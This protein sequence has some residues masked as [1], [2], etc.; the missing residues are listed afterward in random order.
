MSINAQVIFRFFCGPTPPPSFQYLGPFPGRVVLTF[1]ALHTKVGEGQ[2]LYP[3]CLYHHD[4]LVVDGA[5]QPR[6]FFGDAF[7]KMKSAGLSCSLVRGHPPPRSQVP[8]NG[9]IE[10][11]SHGARGIARN[12]IMAI[13]SLF[14]VIRY[15]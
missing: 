13:M 2:V 1:T 7:V 12:A 14:S 6:A 5:L 9:I 8:P 11:Q 15:R 3:R 10:H 4:S